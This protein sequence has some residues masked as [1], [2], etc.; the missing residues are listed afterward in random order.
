MHG[1]HLNHTG[2]LIHLN[3]AVIHLFNAGFSYVLKLMA[4]NEKFSDGAADETAHNQAEGCGCN[5]KSQAPY[6]SVLFHNR[7]K[8]GR[9]PYAAHQGDRACAHAEQ[10]I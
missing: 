9:R 2:F 8:S 5:G 10:R 7:S 6:G 4:V 1:R 3:T